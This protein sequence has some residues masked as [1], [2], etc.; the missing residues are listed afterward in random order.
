LQGSKLLA[1]A[2]LPDPRAVIYAPTLASRQKIVF[3]AAIR[4]AY[5][6]DWARTADASREDE[7]SGSS[8]DVHS[9]LGRVSYKW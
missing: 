4:F 6:D 2:V 9:V 8:F 3:Q 1:A 7:I 5:G